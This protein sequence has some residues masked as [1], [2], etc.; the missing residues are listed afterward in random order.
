MLAA[1]FLLEAA[2]GPLDIFGVWLTED[3]TSQIE[4]VREDDTVRGRII[5][6]E[7]YENDIVFDTENPDPALRD[8][9]LLGMPILEGFEAGGNKWRRGAIYDPTDGKTYRSALHR[10]DAD[11]LAVEGCVA[12]IC[13]TQKWARVPEDEVIRGQRGG[14]VATGE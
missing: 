5:W 2:I 9:D 7:D 1:L 8:R 6:Y 11:T 14:G 13:L 3:R 10:L 4:I 12:V